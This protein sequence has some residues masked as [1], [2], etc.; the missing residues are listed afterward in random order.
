MKERNLRGRLAFTLVEL[1]VVIAIIGILVGLLL[2][3]VQAAREAARRMQCGNNCKQ[4]GLAIHNYLDTYRFLPYQN[5]RTRSNQQSGTTISWMTGILPFIEQGPLFDTLD[6]IN[7]NNGTWHGSLDNP[8]AQVARDT[9]I[10]AYLCPSN[11]Q[12][13]HV[14]SSGARDAIGVLANGNARC[15][16]N[17]AR[18]DYSGNLGFIWTGWKDCGDSSLAALRGGDEW[19]QSDRDFGWQGDAGRLQRIKGPFW[20][21][22]N[23]CNDSSF[24]DGMS[25]TIAVFENHSWG[26]N[27]QTAAVINKQSAWFFPFTAVDSLIKR[28]NVGPGTI[29]GGNGPDDGRCS[30]WQSTHPGGAQAVM[31]DGSVKFVGETVD[32]LVQIA[33]STMSGGESLQLP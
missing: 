20:Y 9:E 13:V 25:N 8:Q 32:G 23:G 16:F 17:T 2:P 11:P 22:N 31:G 1:L 28:M 5:D 10:P 24:V 19:V 33:A 18:T 15:A 3:A 26:D 6:F 21:Q 29:A 12:P 7:V 4:I 30:G 14:G 27:R